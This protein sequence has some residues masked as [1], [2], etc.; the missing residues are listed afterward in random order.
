MSSEFERMIEERRLTQI[1]VDRDLTLKEIRE[2]EADLIEAKDSLERNRFKWATIQGYYSMFH[3]AR[4]L[5]YSRGFREKSHY[6]LLVALRNLFIKDLGTKLI[7]DFEGAMS[8]RQEADY[9]LTFSEAGAKETIE[10]AEIFLKKAK[11]IL[12]I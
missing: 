12:K 11:E 4:A 7:E 1:K 6:A 8:L 3:A 2:A 10:A 5:I 9:G